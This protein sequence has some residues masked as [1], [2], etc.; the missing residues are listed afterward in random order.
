MTPLESARAKLEN[1]ERG[2]LTT[3]EIVALLQASNVTPKSKMIPAFIEECL[4]ATI[5]HDRDQARANLNHLF[6]D[7]EVTV[8][9]VKTW[10]D[11]DFNKIT[12][13]GG[14]K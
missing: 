12:S 7:R 1:P 14:P 10:A 13:F 2:A 6:M 8:A 4:D 9:I 5:G 11:T 3:Q